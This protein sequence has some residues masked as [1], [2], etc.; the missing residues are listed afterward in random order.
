MDESV[1]IEILIPD[2]PESTKQ[3]QIS[4]IYVNEGQKVSEGDVLFDVETDK[5]VLEVVSQSAGVID[6]FQVVTGDFVSANQLA[7]NVRSIQGNEVP[8]E[9]KNIVKV[10]NVSERTVKDDS[11]RIQLEEVIGNSLFDKRGIICGVLGLVMGIVIGA[12]FTA[13]LLG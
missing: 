10:E 5:V 1:N 2:L 13:I 12:I 8:N 11:G 6:N 9:S 7:M 3:A 4:T